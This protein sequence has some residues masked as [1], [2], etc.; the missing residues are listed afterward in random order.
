MEEKKCDQALVSV[1]LMAYEHEAFIRDAMNGIMMQKTDFLTEVV[2]G[3]DFSKDKTLEIIRSYEDTEKISIRILEREVGDSYWVK[4]QEKGRLYNFLNILE[5]CNGKYVALLD[6]DDYWTDP[7]K[8]QKQVDIMEQAPDL[9]ICFHYVN[10][11]DSNGKLLD[12][13]EVLDNNEVL[14]EN[15]LSGEKIE[16]RTSSV[17]FRNDKFDSTLFPLNANAGDFFIKLAL[18]SKGN[19]YRILEAMSNYRIHDKSVW[20]SEQSIVIIKRRIVDQ[21]IKSKLYDKIS[22]LNTTLL[23]LYFDFI[24]YNTIHFL[25]MK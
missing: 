16:T 13:H 12:K 25:R 19:G 17:L 15:V 2:I 20:S 9:S 21:Q 18:L 4:R 22:L 14:F 7:F 24:K 3:D 11:V 1:R 23:M 6:G 8:L 10:K 5:N